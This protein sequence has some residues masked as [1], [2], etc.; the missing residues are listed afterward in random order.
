MEAGVIPPRI[1]GETKKAYRAFIDYCMM[2]PDRTIRKL[3]QACIEDVS[4]HHRLGTLLGW[5]T[6]H[7]WQD[8]VIEY[9]RRAAEQREQE[10]QRQR[11]ET[12]AQVVEDTDSMIEWWASRRAS[13]HESTKAVPTMSYRELVKMRREIDDLRRRSLGLPDRAT[14]STVKGTG[15]SGEHIIRV[16]WDNGESD[17]DDASST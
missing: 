2:G 13:Y 11:I 3:Y 16:I 17:S 14:E 5:S 8:R 15:E 10:R 4:R 12:E 6:R 7:H 9:E 1:E